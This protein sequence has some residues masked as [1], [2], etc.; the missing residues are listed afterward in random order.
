VVSQRFTSPTAVAPAGYRPPVTGPLV[1]LRPFAPPLTPYGPGHLG[2]DLALA[3][4]GEVVAASAGRVAFAGQ[5]AGR[6]VVVIA[7][8]DGLRTEYEPVQPLV[9]VGAAVR[10]GALIGRLRG[11][12]AGCPRSGCLHWGARRGAAYVDPLALLRPL[13]VVRLEPWAPP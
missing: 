3:P 10:G 2:V 9:R 13:G 8:P 5:V 12:H 1:V 6:G 4:D 7:H 11:A